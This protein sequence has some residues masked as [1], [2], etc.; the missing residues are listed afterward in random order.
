MKAHFVTFESPGTFVHEATTLPIDSWDEKK[1]AKMAHTIKERH[2]ATPFA[3][4]FTTRSR[5]ESELDSKVTKTSGRFFLGGV[6]KTIA[7]IEAENDPRNEILL[8]N[9][10][11]ND[12]P[13]IVV[14]T[15]SW[16][17]AQP[18]RK[19]DVVLDWKP[20]K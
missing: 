10:K 1:A 11:F 20:K 5:S 4:Y 3:F 18:L 7:G 12:Y 6:I 16:K 8:N 15:N 19:N 9:M 14:N 17:I 2:G 13:K